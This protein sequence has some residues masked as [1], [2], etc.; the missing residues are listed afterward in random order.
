MAK[1]PTWNE[2]YINMASRTTL[3]KSVLASQAIYLLM[4]LVFPLEIIDNMEILRK[5]S[6]VGHRQSHGVHNVR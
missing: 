3:V 2:K 1:N 4:P 5:I 6:L